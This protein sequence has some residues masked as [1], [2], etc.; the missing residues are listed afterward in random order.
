MKIKICVTFFEGRGH[1]S[2]TIIPSDYEIKKYTRSE[3]YFW[4]LDTGSYEIALQGVSGG[5]VL[6]EVLNEEDEE[7]AR[8]EIKKQ[9]VFQRSL[10]INI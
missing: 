6:I 2:V 9:G 3:C 5:R 4:E 1:C 10:F 8:K 7:I